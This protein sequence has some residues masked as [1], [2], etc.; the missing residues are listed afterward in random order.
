MVRWS[1]LGDGLKNVANKGELGD[2]GA[3]VASLWDTQERTPNS[4]SEGFLL[5]ARGLRPQFTRPFNDSVECLAKC[6]HKFE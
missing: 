3:E 6:Q 2:K 4:E 1:A 5:T